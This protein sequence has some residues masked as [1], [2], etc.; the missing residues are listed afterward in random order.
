[1]IEGFT[2]GGSGE[3]SAPESS[4]GSNPA[5]GL[6]GVS[7]LEQEPGGQIVDRYGSNRA[8]FNPNPSAPGYRAIRTNRYLFVAYANGQEDLYDMRR[9]P[10]QLANAASSPR[11]SKVRIWLLALLNGYADCA[12]EECRATTGREPLPLSPARR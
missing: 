2:R 5:R 10:H 1:M 6:E 11:Y 7:D 4:P 9:D 12:G 8:L 3:N